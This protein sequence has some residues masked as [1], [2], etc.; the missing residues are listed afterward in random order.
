MN[1]NKINWILILQA[2]AMLWVVIGHSRVGT[3]PGW[4][5]YA[6]ALYYFASSFHMPLFIFVSGYLFYITRI[7]KK[8]P[9]WRMIKEKLER[10]GIPFVVFT[11]AALVLKSIFSSEMERPVTLNLSNFLHG[12]LYPAD[13]PMA[14]MWFIA[15]LFWMFLLYPLWQILCSKAIYSIVG[16]TVLILIGTIGKIPTEL[17]CLNR[18]SYMAMYFFCGVCFARFKL[19]SYIFDIKKCVCSLVVCVT[20]YSIAAYFDNIVFTSYI[21]IMMSLAL[22]I[23]LD[24]LYAH[25]FS[26]YRNYTYQIFLLGIFGQV[27]VNILYRHSQCPFIIGYLIAIIIG[28]YMPVV[29]AKIIE[30]VNWKPLKMSIGLK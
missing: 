16:M 23:I 21:G 9:Y 13:S 25:I 5:Q 11:A 7:N 26:S 12:F 22:S 6:N 28:L 8:W 18:A 10:L 30:K 19:T 14:E 27:F 24:K 17:F 2:W 1:K 4:P 29:V 20:L 3:E 15:T